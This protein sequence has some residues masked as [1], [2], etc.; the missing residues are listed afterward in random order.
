MITKF[1]TGMTNKMTGLT[2]CHTP[3]LD[4]PCLLS[5]DKSHQM[6]L[7][8]RDKPPDHVGHT[9]SSAVQSNFENNVRL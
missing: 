7:R 5:E 9:G 3:G 2:Y 8:F 6:D 1:G 4:A